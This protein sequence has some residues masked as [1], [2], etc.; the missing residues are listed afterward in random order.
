MFV[1]FLDDY[2]ENENDINLNI[3][4]FILKIKKTNKQTS[5]HTHINRDQLLM[6][7][8]PVIAAN[9]YFVYLIALE[10][11]YIAVAEKIIN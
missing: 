6:S 7:C 9:F 1:S 3:Y 8:N 11:N 5:T 2:K 10:I 4:S